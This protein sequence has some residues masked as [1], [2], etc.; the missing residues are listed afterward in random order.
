MAGSYRR[1]PRRLA[2]NPPFV[3]EGLSVRRGGDGRIA[4]VRCVLSRHK[5]AKEVL[6]WCGQTFTRPGA[7]GVRE[8]SPFAF[9][10]RLADLVPSPRKYRHRNQGVLAPNH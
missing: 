10:D 2:D 8:F 5:A 3:P 4:P 6:P 9:L 1:K 7:N